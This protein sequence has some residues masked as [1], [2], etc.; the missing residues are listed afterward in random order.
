MTNKWL[1][2]ILTTGD[3]HT[4]DNTTNTTETKPINNTGP[5]PSRYT[6]PPQLQIYV[7]F[8]YARRSR[9]DQV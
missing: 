1:A 8:L 6:H 5:R 2:T 3:I 4:A 7:M 9:L